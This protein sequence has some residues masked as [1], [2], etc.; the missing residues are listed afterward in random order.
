M[1]REPGFTITDP[2]TTA[3]TWSPRGSGSCD[4]L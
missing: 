2:I 4:K 1:S 3:P